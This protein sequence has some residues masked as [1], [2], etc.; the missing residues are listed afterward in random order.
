MVSGSAVEVFERKLLVHCSPV[1]AG[2]KP[3]NMFSCPIQCT[4]RC[5]SARC[6]SLSLLGFLTALEVC[7]SRL[8]PAD[9]HIAVL[10]QR[11][12]GMLLLVYRPGLLH[13]AVNE[14]RA[15]AF[16]R[17]LGY[18][19]C[20]VHRCIATLSQRIARSDA[21]AKHE[22]RCLFPHEVGL[23][24]GYPYD[25]VRGFMDNAGQDCLASG[26]WKVYARERDAA[27]CFCRYK[28]CTRDCRAAYERGA[29]LAELAAR[30]RDVAMGRAA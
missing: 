27:D 7:S 4:P 10:A 12:K 3:A 8:L 16:L 20:D 30:G 24:L 23:F 2:L 18:E 29:A 17:A 9:V 1:I 6:A 15:A 19:P 11:E 28:Q 13:D 22:R 5:G 26:C 25:D 14:P 21:A